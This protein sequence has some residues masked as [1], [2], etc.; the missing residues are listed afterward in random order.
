MPVRM[1]QWMH[2]R[3]S[4]G[5]EIVW[6]SHDSNGEVWFKAHFDLLDFEATKTTDDSLAAS[7]R[8]ILKAACRL[9][10][11]FLSKWKKYRIDIYLEFNRAWG[12]GSSST[13][14][15]C[16]AQWA[17]VNPYILL[18]NTLGGSGYDVACALAD[19]PIL[20]QL[21]DNELHISHVDF[22]PPFAENLYFVYLGNKTDSDDARK[23]YYKHKAN[24]NGT[25]KH[26]SDLSED[27]IESKTLQEFESHLARH[28][29]LIAK[30]LMLEPVQKRLFSDYWG[31][32]KSLGAWGGDFVL[33][34]SDRD[35]VTTR[36]YFKEKGLD[37]V[38]TL[39]E[40]LLTQTA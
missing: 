18:F 40:L 15:S 30:S 11:D 19:G 10:S 8:Q 29:E 34:T 35:Q 14:I 13:L 16:I 21:G 37:T 12:F 5:S 3:E 17:E 9:N 23:H 36:A 7:L 32:V 39:E 4:N 25:L 24:S 1:G 27:I 28:E 6:T 22:D 31:V 33:A 20:Y 26:I 38:F 2:V